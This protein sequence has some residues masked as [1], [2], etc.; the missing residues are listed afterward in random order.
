MLL[1]DEAKAVPDFGKMPSPGYSNA[2]ASPMRSRSPKI[3][4][5]S[6]FTSA[7]IGHNKGFVFGG[8]RHAESQ[9]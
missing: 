7:K 3:F 2:S 5:Q 1:V 8:C 6:T 4:S 9:I